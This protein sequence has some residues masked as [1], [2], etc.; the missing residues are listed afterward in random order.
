MQVKETRSE[1]LKREYQVVL[2]AKDL[3]ERLTGQLIE[4]KDKVR[5]IHWV[6]E[7]STPG[8]VLMPDGCIKTGLVEGQMTEVVDGL[9]EVDQASITGEP[10]PVLKQVGEVSK[11]DLEGADGVILGG[12][13]YFANIPGEM[14]TI[15]DD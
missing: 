2:P 1:G 6:P 4:L 5:I 14:K 15:L 9:S 7:K 11:E 13:T 10:L 3:E 12:P 8:E